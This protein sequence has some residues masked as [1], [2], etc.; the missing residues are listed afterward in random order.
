MEFPQVAMANRDYAAFL[1]TKLTRAVPTGIARPGDLGDGLFPFQRDLTT[2]A[3]RRG[4]AAIFA[5]TGLGKTRMEIK[6]ARRVA[7]HTGQPVLI[8]APL[9]VAAQTALQ[10]EAIG[11]RV[12]ICRA[13]SDVRPGVNITNYERLHRFDTSAFGGVAPD[14]SSCIK[15]HDAKTFSTLCSA[16]A[17]TPFKL[18]ATATPSP[19]DYTELGTHAEFLGICSRAEM[20]S[21]FFCHDGGDTS[22]W[23]LKGHARTA[24]WRFVASWGALVR[25]PSDL[26]YSDDG[27]IL[28]PLNVV[29]HIVD[30]NDAWDG[31][32][33]SLFA[34]EARTLSE[35]RSAR[36]KSISRRV[37]EAAALANADAS[38]REPWILWCDLNAE[39][40]ALARAVHGAV[41]VTG[42]QEIDEKEARLNAFTRGE[43]R[44]I[45]SK[46]SICGWGLNWQHCAN[47][48]FVG[49]SDSW[50]SYYQA[51]RRCNR[52]GQTR[53]VNIHIFTSRAEGAVIANLKRKEEDA[54]RMADELSA[55][56][57]AIVREEVLGQE[58]LTN[59]Y[60]PS[61]AME[62]PS[63]LR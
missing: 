28:P 20:L 60:A 62:V 14:E 15:H 1:S 51:G 56:T 3:L 25:R 4:R 31:S 8:L 63:W 53:Q 9:A 36:K 42:S 58:R 50:E 48:A 49:I 47:V 52:F 30:A 7:D 38:A 46:T 40:E 57:R 43:A 2:W 19:N 29:H 44:V 34:T 23:R 54:A 6:W 26:G 17:R 59:E 10:G 16:F 12:T 33:S 41:E 5:D 24:F 32:F 37:A 18:C 55:E 45:V 35:R 21:E 11:E 22:T 61:K 27:Y 39:S 13:Q